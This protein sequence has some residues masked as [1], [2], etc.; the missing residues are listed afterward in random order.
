MSETSDSDDDQINP[1]EINPSLVNN[2]TAKCLWGHTRSA[3]R[4]HIH[5]QENKARQQRQ[6]ENTYLQVR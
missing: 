6:S 3:H 5:S 4:R 1:I 2:L